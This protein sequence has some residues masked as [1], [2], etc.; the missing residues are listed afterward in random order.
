MAYEFRF[1]WGWEKYKIN[2]LLGKYWWWEG[3][4]IGYFDLGRII[5]MWNMVIE[6]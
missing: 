3:G 5:S 1:S 2:V 4:G 6:E